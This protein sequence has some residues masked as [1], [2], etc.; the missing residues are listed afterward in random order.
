MPDVTVTSL[1]PRVQKQVENAQTA[2]QRGNLDYVL[3]VAG[4]VLK[5]A[6]G[7]LPVRRLLRTA[8]LRHAQTKSKLGTRMFGSV[9]QAGFM[10]GSSKEPQKMLDNAEKLLAAD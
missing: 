3:E 8:Q 5:A 10:F 2:L 6:P 7:C 4:Q 9:T 1:D